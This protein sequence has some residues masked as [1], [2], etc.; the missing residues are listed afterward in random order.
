MVELTEAFL[1]AL[2]AADLHAMAAKGAGLHPRLAQSAVAVS[3]AELKSTPGGFSAYL[4]IHNGQE[5]Y[6]MRLLAKMQLDVLSPVGLGADE[7]RTALDAVS[8]VLAQGVEGVS[9]SQITAYAPEYDRAGD[10]FCAKLEVDCHSWLCA[11][12]AQDE[13]GTLEHFILKGALS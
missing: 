11:V 2:T 10:Y 9:I 4:G 8:E 7:C 13:S 5:L 3:V 12:P 1:D 6:G